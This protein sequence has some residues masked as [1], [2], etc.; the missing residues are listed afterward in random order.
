MYQSSFRRNPLKANSMVLPALDILT[1]V[2][3][4]LAINYTHRMPPRPLSNPPPSLSSPSIS[5]PHLPDIVPTGLLLALTNLLPLCAFLVPPLP[6]PALFLVLTLTL[7]ESNLI[8]VLVTNILKVVAS[9]PRPYFA[10][11]CVSYLPPPDVTKCSGDVNEVAEALK[12][13]PSGHSALGFSAATVASLY[14][15]TLL[16]YPFLS[17]NGTQSARTWKFGVILM[18]LMGAGWMALS[19]TVD[20]HHHFADI[21]G[22]SGIGIGIGFLVYMGRLAMIMKFKRDARGSREEDNGREVDDSVERV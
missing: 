14:L 17:C 8:T 3:L 10:S 5:H 15:A 21:V 13:F 6:T 18:P 20:F 12:S 19:R 9:R 16:V 4:F 1:F 22:G 2:A 7:L 11:V